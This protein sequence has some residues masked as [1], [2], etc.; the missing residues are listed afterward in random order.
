M[1]EI[2]ILQMGGEPILLKGKG[3]R[4]M[5]KKNIS[6]SSKLYNLL[7]GKDTEWVARNLTLEIGEKKKHYPK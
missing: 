1:E 5:F 2:L 3:F 7:T 6:K 4:Q